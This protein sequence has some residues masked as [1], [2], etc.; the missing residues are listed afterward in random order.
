MAKKRVKGEG[1]P[2]LEK[3]SGSDSAELLAELRGLIQFARIGVAQAVNSA[4]VLLYW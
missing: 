2:S 1:L 3:R 4:Q